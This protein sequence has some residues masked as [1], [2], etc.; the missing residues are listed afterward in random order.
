MRTWASI[1]TVRPEGEVLVVGE[2][3]VRLFQ[4]R[5][6]QFP[7]VAPGIISPSKQRAARGTRGE[8]ELTCEVGGLRAIAAPSMVSPAPACVRE[9]EHQFAAVRCW[10]LTEHVDRLRVQIYRP[11]TRAPTSRVTGLRALVATVAPPSGSAA[12]WW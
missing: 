9:G 5:E 2:H 12:K 1:A 11:R 8:V 7:E 4:K 3:L 10:A 6:T